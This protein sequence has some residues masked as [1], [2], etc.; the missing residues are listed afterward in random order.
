[1]VDRALTTSVVYNLSVELMLLRKGSTI[2]MG[3]YQ[4]NY[5]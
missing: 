2:Y 4:F 5:E 1:M 3:I